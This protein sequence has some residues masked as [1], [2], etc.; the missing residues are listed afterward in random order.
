[1]AANTYSICDAIPLQLFQNEN[2]RRDVISL[3]QPR[4][5]SA[6]IISKT[7]S[8]VRK[9]FALECCTVC[10][11]VLFN[12]ELSYPQNFSWRQQRK[13]HLKR[14]WSKEHEV[15]RARSLSFARNWF[16]SN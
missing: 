8:C 16:V 1:L 11:G 9:Y 10:S 3:N 7:L 13:F 4:D 2:R 15:Y 12:F 6:K 5:M 14:D